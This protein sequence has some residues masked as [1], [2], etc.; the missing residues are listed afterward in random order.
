MRVQKTL[1]NVGELPEEFVANL[2]SH[3]PAVPR[4]LLLRLSF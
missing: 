4:S 3:Q 2:A 1:G